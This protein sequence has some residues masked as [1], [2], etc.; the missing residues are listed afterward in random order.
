MFTGIG[1]DIVQRTIPGVTSLPNTQTILSGSLF[2][3]TTNNNAD[4]FHVSVDTTFDSTPISI[5]F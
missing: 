4:G 2:G 1:G 3:N 5:P